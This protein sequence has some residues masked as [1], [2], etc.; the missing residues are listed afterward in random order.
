MNY[1]NFVAHFS[2]SNPNINL[3]EVNWLRGAYNPSYFPSARRV[4]SVGEAIAK[5]IGLNQEKFNLEL[6]TIV[7][8]S[9]G[10]HAAG[11]GKN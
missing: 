11:F 10:A 3:I 1:F 6:L 5:F 2:D 7:G 9:L 8:H 4:P